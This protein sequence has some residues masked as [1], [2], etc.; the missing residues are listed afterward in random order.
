M[1]ADDASEGAAPAVHLR[2]PGV[3]ERERI[4]RA[5]SELARRKRAIQ[6]FHT[7][8]MSIDIPTVVGEAKEPDETLCPAEYLYTIHHR[9]IVHAIERTI[10]RP[11][12]R[13]LIQAPPGSAKSTYASVVLPPY[14]M[15]RRQKFKFILASYGS[16]LAWVQSGRAMQIVDSDRYRALAWPY[17][18]PLMLEKKAQAHWSMNNGSECVAAG[19]LAGI[20]GHRADGWVIDDPVA[21]QKEADSPS[22]RTDV[23]NAYKGDLLTRVKPEAWG[24]LIQTR[25]HEDD[26]AGRILPEKYKGQSGLILCRDGLEWEVLNL[27]AKAEQPDDPL[28]RKLGEY[29]WPEW[30]PP[31]HWAI[32]EGGDARTWSSLY[33]QNPTPAGTGQ[34]TKDKVNWYN[35]GEAPMRLAKVMAGDYAVTKDGGDFTEYGV[36]GL[37]SNSNMW[38]LDWW[39]GQESSDVWIAGTLAMAQR[40]GV[41]IL[42]NEGGVIDKATRP[43][44]NKAMRE[45]KDLSG[46]PAPYFVDIR[47]IA[48][49]ADKVA[50]L[51]SFQARWSAGT[52]WLPKG[53]AWAERLVELLCAFPAARHDDGP[54]VCGLLGRAIDQMPMGQPPPAER[55]QGIQPFTAE[56]LEYEEKPEQAI[57]YQ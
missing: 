33:Q 15:G 3:S 13:L 31:Q 32:F 10:N 12:G 19:L 16:E 54:D 52:V 22:N 29:L 4:R 46:Q 49:M 6:S 17:D 47:S 48:S 34:F 28:G 42:F 37:D 41:K 21:G 36:V 8:G 20:T 50:K 43:A 39:F 45:L 24:I 25:W 2:L 9:V 44:F 26:L 55:K 38:F 27:P 1:E 18:S 53:A 7:F 23:W 11:F 56:W 30:F 57:R 40:H 51:Q 14:V 35:P 5:A